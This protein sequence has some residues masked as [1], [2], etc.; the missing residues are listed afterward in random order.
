M[1]RLPEGITLRDLSG[2]AEFRAAE[3][4][5]RAVW[6]EDDPADPG[7]LMM[8]IAQEGGLV[9]GT[10]RGET[11]LGYVFG[12]P[13]R[14]P[15]VQHSH[16]LAVLPSARGHGLA[17]A[18]KRYQREWCLARGI[19]LVRWTF[20]PLRHANASLNISRL[21]A[22]GA[23]YCQDYYGPMEGINK[24]APSDRLLVEWHL[25][26]PQVMALAADDNRGAAFL[27]LPE[28]LRVHI[29]NDFGSLLLSDPEAAIAERLRLRQFLVEHLGAG[30]AITDYD[31]QQRSYVLSR[32]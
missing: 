2:M 28:A 12:F 8:V 32:N 15:E 4:L 14:D 18:L 11:L 23:T 10:F 21:G 29:P 17:L 7:D 20:D 31:T 3:A 6:G 13:T 19:T 25:A 26:S 24:G 22:R 27:G 30:Y 16:R 1:T 9:A 5:Q